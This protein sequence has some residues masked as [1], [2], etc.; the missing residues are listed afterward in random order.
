VNAFVLAGGQSTR[1]GRDKAL[2]DLNGSPLIVRALEK[3]RLLGFSPR[4][5]GSRPDLASFAPVIP[6]IHPHSGPLGGIEAA[7]AASDTEQNLFLPVDLPLVL[8]E[9]L[10]WMIRRAELTSALATIPRFQGCLQPLCAVY[11]K[12]LLPHASAAIASGNAKVT[13]A[14]ES[15]AN[16]TRMRIDSFDVESIAVAQSWQQ[17]TPL[18]RWFE[19]VNTPADFDKAALEQSA[20]IH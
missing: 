8:A 12:V 3:L 5:V 1:M 17:P 18:H 16:A 2:L 14:I 7:L 19:N 9:L 20:R 11:S 4:I 6:D 15:A 10:R 13:R